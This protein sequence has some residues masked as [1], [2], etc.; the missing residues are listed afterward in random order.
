MQFNNGNLVLT[1]TQENDTART[2][3]A[4]FV[5]WS[6]LENWRV[7]GYHPRVVASL[8]LGGNNRIN[9]NSRPVKTNHNVLIGHNGVH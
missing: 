7:N 6:V 2:S 3:N 1:V 5:E 4:L 8:S 9:I